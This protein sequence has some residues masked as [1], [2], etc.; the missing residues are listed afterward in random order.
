MTNDSERQL[1]SSIYC[2]QGAHA[3]RGGVDR[4]KGWNVAEF[5]LMALPPCHK[6]YQAFVSIDDF[7]L[8]GYD[9]HPPI[10]LPIAV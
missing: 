1:D 10:K 2:R 8:E 7:D 3:R 9:P 5:D 4:S 6:T